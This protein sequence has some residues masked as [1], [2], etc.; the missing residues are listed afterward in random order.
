M[1]GGPTGDFLRLIN[2]TI[3]DQRNHY[4][5]DLTDSGA[6]STIVAELDFRVTSA[7][8][9]ADGFSLQFLPTSVYGT[10]GVGPT[11]FDP[12][13]PNIAETAAIGFDIWEPWVV[14]DVSVHHNGAE[15]RNV[16]LNPADVDLDIGVFHHARV[17]M[18]QLANGS[19]VSLQLTPDIH[20]VPGAT[21]TAFNTF[22]SGLLPYENRI[23]FSARTGGANMD[24]DLDNISVDYSNP[25]APLPVISSATLIQDFDSAGTTNFTSSQW[26]SD[27]GP[28]PIA[29]GPT[30][31][32]LRLVNNDVNS[33][34]N[35]IA[36][37][38]GPDGGVSN[39]LKAEFDFCGS[40]A[41][42]ADGFSIAL[43]PTATYGSQGAGVDPAPAEEPNIA[44]GLGIGFDVYPY[45][46]DPPTNRVTIF[47]DGNMVHEAQLDLGDIDLDAGVFHHAE[48][49]AQHVSGGTAVT[50]TLTPDI[51]GTPGSPVT[52]VSDLLIPDMV[53]YDYRLQFAGR[54]GGANM[55]VDLDNIATGAAPG[56][57]PLY[58]TQNFEG[59]GSFYKGHVSASFPGPAIVNE[60]GSNGNFL[61]LIHDNVGGQNS[62][63]SFD[64]ASD[65]DVTILAKFD[66]RMP[67]ETGH[68]GCCGERADGF[69]LVLADTSVY[70][71]SAMAGPGGQV[72]WE[73]PEPPLP[74]AL[75]VA[76][77]IFSGDAE[78][79]ENTVI[80][81]WD[82]QRLGSYPVDPAVAFDLNTGLFNHVDLS[83]TQGT[84]GALAT[85]TIT[86]DIFG[87]PGTP[88]T[89][90]ANEPIPGMDVA[91]FDFRAGFGARSGGAFTSV[92]LDNISIITVPEPASLAMVASL[93][94]A[95]GLLSAIRRRKA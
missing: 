88:V 69:A 18:Q 83:V 33:N 45:F 36:F 89:V 10:T 85:L 78:H 81:D 9:G 73:T 40:G 49:I 52:V 59:G 15:R 54:T 94:A 12:E 72:A 63:V 86:P 27:P 48:L 58:T 4:S 61:R 64:R 35:A 65:P 19:T 20:G 23:Q 30:G 38:R 91:N 7:D 50:L 16:R 14:N 95:F 74:A 55:S 13:E 32:F 77:D 2:D 21:I 1:S 17:E 51:H 80:L 66:Y 68:T 84:G 92:D 11:A 3:N 71:A 37:D 24:V 82:G 42:P 25:Y 6:F 62:M 41:D 39:S 34:S 46:S 44:G 26:G 29:G 60:G 5:Y 57:Q 47:Y 31:H 53:P 87:M 79:N 76:F 67:D 56:P 43:L 90:F 28:M 22:V 93:L 70:G 75:V 8:N